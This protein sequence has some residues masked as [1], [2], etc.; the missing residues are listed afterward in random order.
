METL[1]SWFNNNKIYYKNYNLLTIL[2]AK[3][4]LQ[5]LNE[6]YYSMNIKLKL[7]KIIE[8]LIIKYSHIFKP[9]ILTSRIN[10][11]AN[12]NFY[13]VNFNPDEVKTFL[14]I[15]NIIKFDNNAVVG[16]VSK[17]T[18]KYYKMLKIPVIF[19]DI[20]YKL[21]HD[22]FTFDK[23]FSANEFLMLHRAAALIDTLEKTIIKYQY[24][25]TLITVQDYYYFDSIFANFFKNKIP[26]ITLQHG[27][28]SKM[29]NKDNSLWNFVFS[30]Y[31]IVWGKSQK[32][33]LKY[34]NINE[35]KIKALGTARYDDYFINNINNI[36]YNTK[37]IDNKILFSIQP[38]NL[39]EKDLINYMIK[40]IGKIT[41]NNE[42][43]LFLRFHPGNSKEAKK[44]FINSLKRENIINFKVSEEED[45]IKDIISSR[46]VLSNRS[47]IA[48]ETMLFNKPLIEYYS[49]DNNTFDYRNA[50]INALDIDEIIQYIDRI[51]K[52]E[53]FLLDVLKKQKKFIN[54]Y[55]KQ[56]PSSKRILEFINNQSKKSGGK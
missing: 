50:V 27:L 19:F 31:I 17:K 18:Y 9:K 24:P 54:Q 44:E 30:D 5:I 52:E 32:E 33:I 23:N 28:I 15:H 43:E 39:L 22:K 36:N 49:I 4:Y 12:K 10:S 20:K 1:R 47:G 46:I 51:F 37:I 45:V 29:E 25:K 40:L 55:F 13:I 35:S 34:Y 16:T 2:V 48:Y 3:K 6:N 8:N 7:K 41:K 11:L 53:K 14:H 42:Y 38:L 56:P 21:K 26:T